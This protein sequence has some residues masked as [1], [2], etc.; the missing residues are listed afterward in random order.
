M[1]LALKL[2][3][4][5]LMITLATLTGRRWGPVISGWLIGFPLTSGPVSFILASQ[6]GRPFAV[7]AAIGTLGGQLSVLIFCLV[8]SLVARKLNWFFS[9][10]L[11]II[12]FLSATLVS[13]LFTLHLIP[14]LLIVIL[15]TILVIRLIPRVKSGSMD[16]R[17]PSWDIPARILIATTFVFLLTSFAESLGPQLSGLIAPFP[18]YAIVLAT[19]THHQQGAD[20]ARL[21]LHGIA[22]GSFAFISFFGVVAVLLPVLGMLWT[23]LLAV[24][25]T[26]LVNGVTLL[27]TQHGLKTQPIP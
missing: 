25:V 1:I 9:V 14:T 26:I 19:F 17:P 2:L 10:S 3:L 8:Y 7:G 13:S 16:L 22:S 11:A 23:Y 24:V 5:P 20:S 15:A 18:I 21:L 27:L 12:A 6:N 4:T